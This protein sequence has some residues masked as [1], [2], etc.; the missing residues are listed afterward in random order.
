VHRHA[1]PPLPTQQLQHAPGQDRS[2]QV[3]SGLD[4]LA[5]HAS[6]NRSCARASFQ[7]R[8]QVV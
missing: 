7:A 3:T 8:W 6:T 5:T 4:A 1:L 2:V